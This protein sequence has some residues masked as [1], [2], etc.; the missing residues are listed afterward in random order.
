MLDQGGHAYE[1]VKN[2][3]INR[4]IIKKDSVTTSTPFKS[5]FELIVYVSTHTQ[6]TSKNV[7]CLNRHNL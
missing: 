7:N 1:L 6:F 3:R 5:N 2:T 4:V